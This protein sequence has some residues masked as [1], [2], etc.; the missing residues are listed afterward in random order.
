MCGIAGLIGVEPA[1]AAPALERMLDSLGHRGP[2]DRGI[3][4]FDLGNGDVAFLGHTRLSIVELS[5]KGHQPMVD[6]P[7]DRSM[8]PNAVTYNGE[9]YNF[10]ALQPELADL[11]FP[12]HTG[13]DTEVLLAG[14]RAWGTECVHH[15][16]GM[17]AWCL[18][19]PEARTAFLC[20]DA[21]GIKPLYLSA[22][23]SGGLLFASEVRALLAAGEHLVPRKLRRTSLESYL[24]Q[25][26]VFG[27]ESIVDG[28]SLLPAGTTRITDLKG[29]TQREVRHSSL[30]Y[31]ADG[32]SPRHAQVPRRYTQK[33]H[34]RRDDTVLA[35]RS[36]LLQAVDSHLLADVDAGVFLSSGL[37][38][39]VLAALGALT[40]GSALRTVSIGFDEPA[41][42]E[43]S[44]AA[45]I[46]KRL[47]TSHHEVQVTQS[48]IEQVMASV[49]QTLDQPTVDA[50]NSHLVTGAAKDAGLKVA[51][52]GVGADELFGGYAS[53][54]DVPRALAFLPLAQR[55]PLWLQRGLRRPARLAAKTL[56]GSHGRGLAK[57]FE[58][59]RRGD[60]VQLYLLRRELFF[61]DQRRLLFADAVLDASCDQETGV[62]TTLLDE[63]NALTAPLEP[64]DQ[65]SSLEVSLYLRHMLLRDAD[66]MSMA[67]SLEL[68]VPYLDRNVVQVATAA[69]AAWRAPDPRLKPLL[70]DAARPHLP[71]G[72]DALSR[73]LQAKRGFTLPWDRW[74]RGSL[75][76]RVR[77]IF[78][79][80][81]SWSRLGMRPNAA[82]AM[83]AA[84]D[85]GD[86]AVSALQI[87]ALWV[88]SDFAQR[89]G[90]AL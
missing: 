86:P 56:G 13:C 26:A 74:L 7:R 78:A 35:L 70:L 39:T 51:L 81:Q 25:G 43:S 66:T 67:H 37:D 77:E 58:V 46:A 50:F 65:V 49:L 44:A 31:G 5:V 73:G 55:T 83:L 30:R 80:G 17:F 82:L 88:V 84:F 14:Y 27:D 2:D 54:R 60:V 38:S 63:M 53:F 68:R 33:L 6:L 19:D 36:A 32:T 3:K 18:I 16:D 52:S 10:R 59:P 28:I 29:R 79:D 75:N 87:V 42:D 11:G 24:A 12:C 69:R 48:A 45:E 41:L 47:G 71:K 4:R 90:L 57:V 72:L 1:L 9:I 76:Q 8:R 61:A 20:R 34:R 89:H 64:L 23:K 40:R 22:P 85:R 21:L 15:F 62:Q